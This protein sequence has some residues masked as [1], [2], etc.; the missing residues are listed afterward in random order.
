MQVSTW[1]AT[2][3]SLLA[4]VGGAPLVY[5]GGDYIVVERNAVAIGDNPGAVQPLLRT[6]SL[7]PNVSQSTSASRSA[8]LVFE[9]ASVQGTHA[10][11]YLN[12]STLQCADDGSADANQAASIFQLNPHNAN[13]TAREEFYTNHVAFDSSRLRAGFNALMLCARSNTGEVDGGAGTVDDVVV[14]SIVLHY[15]TD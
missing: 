15:Q 2:T 13:A 8:V 5:A 14:R 4:L 9:A 3:L 10:E 11:V 7:P 1:L 12:P 6:F